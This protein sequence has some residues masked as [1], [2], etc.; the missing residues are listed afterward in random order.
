MRKKETAL[1]LAAGN[2]G[3]DITLQDIVDGVEDELLVID[4]E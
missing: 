3:S 4:S 1:Q 2:T